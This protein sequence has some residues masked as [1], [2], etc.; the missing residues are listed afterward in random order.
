MLERVGVNL[1]EVIET[2]GAGDN[3]ESAAGL[4]EPSP[5][6]SPSGIPSRE[7]T[8]FD[9]DENEDEDEGQSEDDEE[10]AEQARRQLKTHPAL[11]ALSTRY[12]GT[13][14]PPLSR[15]LAPPQPVSSSSS[16]DDD[17]VGLDAGNSV[18]QNQVQVRAGQGQQRL[19]T[20]PILSPAQLI[21]INNLN[22]IPHLKK[23]FVYLPASRNSHGAM[24]ARDHVRFAQHLPG[25]LIVDRWAKDF[26]L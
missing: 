4:D 14:T 6:P 9:H 26:K 24:V 2:V 5:C 25:K 3:P 12:D 19:P 20:D 15:P 18:E 11:Q 16:S 23:H 8:L 7:R 17:E 21:I 22:S 13:G 1:R 10:D